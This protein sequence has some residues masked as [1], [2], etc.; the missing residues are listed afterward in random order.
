M[1]WKEVAQKHPMSDPSAKGNES[2]C[3]ITKR[4]QFGADVP[5][6]LQE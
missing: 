4:G 5:L 1:D 6:T 2:R 3:F